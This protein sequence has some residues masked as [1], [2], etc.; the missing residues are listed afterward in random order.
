M[1]WKREPHARSPKK[2]S[3]EL[4]L[5]TQ[6][7]WKMSQ[8]NAKTSGSTD[9]TTNPVQFSTQENCSDVVLL[10]YKEMQTHQD[11]QKNLGCSTKWNLDI[12]CPSSQA[13]LRNPPN[14]SKT[15]NTGSWWGFLHL[16]VLTLKT[17]S[18]L[19]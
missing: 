3:K 11:R 17:P 9:L 7:D 13:H 4:G 14:P 2:L 18:T 5:G 15:K 6:N 10:I 12:P 1:I 16:T 19:V 8:K